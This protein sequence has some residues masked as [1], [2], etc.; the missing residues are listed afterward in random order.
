MLGLTRRWTTTRTKIAALLTWQSAR[1]SRFVRR[2]ATSWR[3][4]GGRAARAACRRSALSRRP[5]GRR[6]RGLGVAEGNRAA[7]RPTHSRGS[8]RGA[9]TGSRSRSPSG[10]GARGHHRSLRAASFRGTQPTVR[11]RSMLRMKRRRVR[12]GLRRARHRP[13]RGDSL[14]L[15]PPPSVQRHD[16]PRPGAPAH[17]ELPRELSHDVKPAGCGRAGDG[18]GEGALYGLLDISGTWWWLVRRRRNSTLRGVALRRPFRGIFATLG[19]VLT[20]RGDRVRS[21]VA[22]LC[23]TGNWLSPASDDAEKP[24]PEPKPW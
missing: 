20:G 6:S 8:S 7:V 11:R 15:S 4:P 24:K 3:P 2:G 13:G 22:P 1:P 9:P 14:L 19:D 10:R 18:C 17:L 5:I 23:T 12:R 16:V 21:P